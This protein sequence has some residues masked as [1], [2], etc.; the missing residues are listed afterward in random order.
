MAR[1]GTRTEWRTEGGGYH[2]TAV[3]TD[4]MKEI[5]RASDLDGLV[6]QRADIL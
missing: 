1:L 2:Q 3:G 5:E 4:R 6:K